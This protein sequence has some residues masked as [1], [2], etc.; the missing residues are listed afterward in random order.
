MSEKR[1]VFTG[2]NFSEIQKFAGS[3]HQIYAYCKAKK[4]VYLCT[5][6]GRETLVAGQY[7]YKSPKGFLYLG[8]DEQ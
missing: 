2:S 7:L 3:S 6:R 4:E 1:I 8:G 5:A